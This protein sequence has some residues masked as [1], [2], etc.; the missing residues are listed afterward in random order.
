MIHRMIRNQESIHLEECEL[1]L[2]VYAKL[3]STLR[4]MRNELKPH[5]EQ[6]ASSNRKEWSTDEEAKHAD[7]KNDDLQIHT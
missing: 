3:P 2:D 7:H 6:L 5:S 4:G 1:P